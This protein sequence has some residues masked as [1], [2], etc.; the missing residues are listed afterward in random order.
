MGNPAEKTTKRPT[1]GDYHR[2]P[3]RMQVLFFIK[4]QPN[5]PVFDWLHPLLP[6]ETAKSKLWEGG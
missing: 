4:N 5:G 1:I 3:V 2:V 6:D